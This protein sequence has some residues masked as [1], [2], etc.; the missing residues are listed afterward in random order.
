MSCTVKDVISCTRMLCPIWSICYVVQGCYVLYSQG[1]YIMYKDVMSCTVKGALSC[2][3]ML[4]HVEDFG[5]L[6]S[7]VFIDVS[8]ILFLSQHFS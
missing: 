7:V 6:V 8:M 4:C 5:G 1:C 2:T 3:R